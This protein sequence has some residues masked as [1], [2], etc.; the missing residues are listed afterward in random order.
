MRSFT[1]QS[2]NISKRIDRTILKKYPS[3]NTTALFR[4]FRKRD[5]KVNGKRVKEDYKLQIDDIIEIYISD[6]YLFGDKN[7]LIK[8]IEKYIIYNDENIIVI[9]K[10]QGISVHPDKNES[11][12]SLIQLVTSYLIGKGEYVRYDGAFPPS[13]C[14]RLDRNTGGLVLIA[15]NVEAH[16]IILK[17]MRSNEI[18]KHYLCYVH[19]TPE[20][21]ENVLVNYLVKDEKKSRVFIFDTKVN[22]S[23]E[24]ITKYRL[25]KSQEKISLLEIELITGKT[26][27][28]RAHLSHI[29]HP[30]VGDGKYGSNLLNGNFKAK[31]QALF[32]YKITFD[33]TSDPGK[34]KYLSGRS[35]EIKPQFKL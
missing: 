4:A 7:D 18:K 21:S 27:Q 35:F 12:N 24:I 33:F 11:K 20:K 5:I 22:N 31:F 23:S 8:E 1:V 15:K 30:I 25:L 2:D 10:P 19:G 28:I 6:E 13:L 16:S 17:K 14:H 32:A 34:L 3:L 26:H 29:G 9:N